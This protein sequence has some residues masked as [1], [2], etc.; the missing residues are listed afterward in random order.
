MTRLNLVLLAAVIASALYLVRVQYESRR[1]YTEIEKAQSE[2]RHLEVEHERLQVEKRA[3]AT[4]GR[5]ERLARE[6][7][8]M[9][10]ASPAITQYVTLRDTP[11]EAAK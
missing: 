1:L 5:V 7:L 8:Q 11:Q 9:R 4:P 2:F 3:Q 6:Q 10:A